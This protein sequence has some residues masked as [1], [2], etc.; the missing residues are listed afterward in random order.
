MVLRRLGGG[1][2]VARGWIEGVTECIA[3]ADASFGSVSQAARGLKTSGSWNTKEE[4]EEEQ[5][6]RHMQRENGRGRG[7][8][9]CVR[10]R[11]SLKGE[12]E[13]V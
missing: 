8:R 3:E 4:K 10:G 13:V 9:R 6:W 7:R 11:W 12:T 2:G 5:R 1:S